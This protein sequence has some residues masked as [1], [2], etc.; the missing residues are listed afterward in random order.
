MKKISRVFPAIVTAVFLAGCSQAAVTAPVESAETSKPVEVLEQ[1][2]TDKTQTVAQDQTDATDKEQVDTQ[3]EEAVETVDTAAPDTGVTSPK[4]I[5]W[6]GDSL[7]QGS[8]GDE[9][10]NLA[11]A[12]YEKLKAMVNVPVQGFGFW[13]YTTHDALWAYTDDSQ[14]NQE[15]DPNKIYIFWLGSNDWV[16]DGV[17]NANTAPVMAEIDK[18]MNGYNGRIRD[19]IVIGTTSRW[20]LGD[21]YVPINRDLA[22][23]YGVHYIDVIDIINQYGYSEDNTHLSQASYDAI[24]VAVYNKLK[25]LGYI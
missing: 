16:V 2:N 7:T 17:P 3:S 14:C 20:R 21:L 15:A 12:P 9:N 18:F 13:G 6:I 22:S 5:V 11:N 10:D 25:A 4:A 24:A 19:Y 1:E 8:L 23:H